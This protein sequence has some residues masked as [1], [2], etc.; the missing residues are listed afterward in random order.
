MHSC[1]CG[2]QSCTA[3]ILQQLNVKCAE[4]KHMGSGACHVTSWSV[5][6][7]SLFQGV[8]GFVA[9]ANPSR[10]WARAGYT[11]DKSSQ[12]PSLMAEATMQGA[13][14]TQGAIWGSV[15]CSRSLRN[16]PITSRPHQV[17]GV[18]ELL[19]F[20]S[21]TTCGSPTYLN[22]SV[23]MSGENDS[24]QAKFRVC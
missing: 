23:I 6:A 4:S 3:A 10:L 14:C 12:G 11:L 2:V 13:N 21:G 8:A 7:L 5:T 16:L 15:S 18:T 24:L 9:G 20:F 19:L 22:L 17:P 1:V